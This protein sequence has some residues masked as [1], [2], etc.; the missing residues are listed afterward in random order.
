MHTYDVI[1]ESVRNPH[2]LAAELTRRSEQGWEVVH[3]VYDG[4]AW[5]HAFIRH[6]GRVSVA[7][8]AGAASDISS[9]TG[10]MASPASASDAVSRVSPVTP[11]SVAQ[12]PVA[13]PATQVAAPVTST[14]PSPTV[15][16][17]SVPDV[18]ANWYKDPSGRYE[19]RYWNGTAWTEHVA[20]GGRQ[21]VDP[22]RS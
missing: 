22:P 11:T 3:I 7:P 4:A 2:E 6:E 16:G 19:L 8:F 10:V 1:S 20:T 13:Q 15:A 18:P 21:S 12:P 17:G 14:T 9:S 5:F